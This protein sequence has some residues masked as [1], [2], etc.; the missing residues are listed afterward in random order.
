L[1]VLVAHLA[2]LIQAG[3]ERIDAEPILLPQPLILLEGACQLDATLP[4]LGPHGRPLASPWVFPRGSPRAPP[5]PR[6]TISPCLSF[7]CPLRGAGPG[8]PACPPAPGGPPCRHPRRCPSAAGLGLAWR[9]VPA[10][11]AGR[12]Q[13]CP[14]PTMSQTRAGVWEGSTSRPGAEKAHGTAGASPHRGVTILRP[15]K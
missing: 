8:P 5:P 3:K 14:C 12:G 13:R 10:P 1:Q 7:S 2:S 9:P 4:V 11:G 6:R 15:A